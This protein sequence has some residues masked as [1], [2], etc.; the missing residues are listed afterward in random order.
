MTNNTT[1]REN[2]MNLI[3]ACAM[4]MRARCRFDIKNHYCPVNFDQERV[5]AKLGKGFKR[6]FDSD[7]LKS[8][9]CP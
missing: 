9:F 5:K 2:T 4:D 1:L 3:A 7:D 6:F 8:D